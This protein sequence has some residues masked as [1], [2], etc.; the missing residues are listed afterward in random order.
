[1]YNLNKKKN[2][3]MKF[4]FY[5]IFIEWIQLTAA[6]AINKQTNTRKKKDEQ[7]K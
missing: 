7:M 4:I 3:L 6:I 1:M 5:I 2:S